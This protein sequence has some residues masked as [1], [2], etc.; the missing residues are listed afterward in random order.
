MGATASTYQRRINDNA[1]QISQIGTN[2]INNAINN[3]WDATNPTI[4]QRLQFFYKNELMQFNKDLL[5]DTNYQ[6]GL[7][8]P[9][10]IKTKYSKEELCQKI[11]DYY[12]LKINLVNYIKDHLESGCRNVE[13]NIASNLELILEGTSKQVRDDAYG[14]FGSLLKLIDN[15]YSQLVDNLKRIQENISYNELR[16][17]VNKTYQLIDTNSQQC[18]QYVNALRDFIWEHHAD[19]QGNVFYY[20]PYLNRSEYQIPKI[21]NLSPILNNKLTT[22]APLTKLYPIPK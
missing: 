7:I 4:C 15:Y 19:D 12:T 2:I 6:L 5:A 1:Q 20:N 17:L 14:R 11:I 18:C 22:C 8:V 21:A 16:E 9:S 10:N 3:G 13:R